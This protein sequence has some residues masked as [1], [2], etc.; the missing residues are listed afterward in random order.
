MTVKI[1][2]YRFDATSQEID[3]FQEVEVNKSD[4]TEVETLFDI[5]SALNNKY[6]GK[7]VFVF[8]PKDFG[9]KPK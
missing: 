1:I 4:K 9:Y 8:E 2:R 5:L 7:N 6:A 3:E